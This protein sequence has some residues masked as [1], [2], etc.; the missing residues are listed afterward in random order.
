MKVPSPFTSAGLIVAVVGIAAYVAG[1]R[2]GWVE[3]MVV[4]AGALVALSVAAPF[5]VGRL[6]LDV[7]R[8][9]EPERVMV[10][11]TSIAILDITNSTGSGIRPRLL[12]DRVAKSRVLVEVPSLRAGQSHQAVY[13][14]PTSRRGSYTIGPA[15]IAR[16]DPLRLLRRGVP[17]AESSTLW[18]HPRYAALSPLPVGFARDLKGQRLTTHLTAMSHSMPCG[19]TSQAM[20]SVIS[21]GCLQRVSVFPW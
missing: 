6:R 7:S 17:Q 18:V 16:Q 3:L 15:V 14:L 8:E 10:G 13:P 12:E 20:T 21:T 1:W 5:V 11:E 4:A 2:L 9:L 19:N